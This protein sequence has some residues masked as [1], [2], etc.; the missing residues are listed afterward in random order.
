MGKLASQ[1]A[2]Q[3]KVCACEYCSNRAHEF[4]QGCQLA[5]SGERRLWSL[6]HAA[7]NVLMLELKPESS[8]LN[9]C[10]ASRI[11]SCRASFCASLCASRACDIGICRC[12]RTS[13]QG[14]IYTLP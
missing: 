11:A 9:L 2:D 8:V 4:H 10:T 6:A 1:F 5:C 7:S 13:S 14:L 3:Q 12:C